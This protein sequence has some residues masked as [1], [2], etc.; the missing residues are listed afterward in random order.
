MAVRENDCSICTFAVVERSLNDPRR[1][2][3]YVPLDAVWHHFGYQK[4]PMLF[5]EFEWQ[6]VGNL[7]PSKK[8]LVYWLKYLKL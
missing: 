4:Q 5:L 2:V 6:D 3:G 7:K 1:P 8:K